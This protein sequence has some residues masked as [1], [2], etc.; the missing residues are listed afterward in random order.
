MRD[1]KD[2]ISV[3]FFVSREAGFSPQADLEFRC[4]ELMDW[5][6]VQDLNGDGVS[7]LVVKLRDKNLFRIYLSHGK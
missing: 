1:R 6:M 2:A 4:P 3:Y 5:W 7:D